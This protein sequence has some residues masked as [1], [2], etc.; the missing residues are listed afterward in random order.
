MSRVQVL[1]LYASTGIEFS[2]E[3]SLWLSQSVWPYSRLDLSAG[4]PYYS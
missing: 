3:G 2:T 1:Q 4:Q